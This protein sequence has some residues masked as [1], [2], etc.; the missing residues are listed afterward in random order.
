MAQPRAGENHDHHRR[1]DDAARAL[2]QTLESAGIRTEI[3]LRNEKIGF[4]IREARTMKIPYLLVLGDREAQEHTVSVTLR[5]G[6]DIGSMPIDALI[7]RMQHE[8]ETKAR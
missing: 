5:G 1:A 7:A 8:I 4:K 6:H 3:D 2:Q